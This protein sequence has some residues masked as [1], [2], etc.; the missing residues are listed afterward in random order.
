MAF[1]ATP[2]RCEDGT[3]VDLVHEP[4]KVW[5]QPSLE[6]CRIEPLLPEA[7]LFQVLLGTLR[8]VV[9]LDCAIQSDATVSYA[10]SSVQ[11]LF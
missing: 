9:V 2:I 8:S 4:D 5:S 1:L 6:I 7:R 3:D 11:A 10:L